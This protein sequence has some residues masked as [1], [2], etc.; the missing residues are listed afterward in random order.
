MA[1]INEQ[2]P[3]LWRKCLSREERERAVVDVDGTVAPTTG[4][5]KEGMGLSYNG[6]W[7]YHPLVVS[8]ANTCELLHL[9]NRPG[10]R[11]SHDGAVEWMDRAAAL[12]R[13][14]F[15]RVCL[16]GDTDVSLTAHFDR[17]T[18]GGVEFAF[19][20]DACAPCVERAEGL[21]EKAWKLLKRPRQAPPFGGGARA[22]RERQGADRRGERV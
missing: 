15:R 17:W 11:P 12:V 19:G 13:R 1:L 22:S 3:R 5:C 8:L 2:R 9:V 10:N 20:M 18:D 4:E 14:A 21:A 6:V 16:R 7:G